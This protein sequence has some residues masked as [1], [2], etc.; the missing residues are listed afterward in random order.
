MRWST[1]EVQL[2]AYPSERPEAFQK[3]DIAKQVLPFIYLTA[4]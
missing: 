1:Q 4:S 3:L 2:P